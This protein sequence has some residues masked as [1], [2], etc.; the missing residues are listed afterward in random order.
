MNFNFRSMNIKHYSIL[1]F[2]LSSFLL[3]SC[4]KQKAK[5][6]VNDR[7]QD[8]EIRGATIC[9]SDAISAFDGFLSF[10]CVLRDN[11]PVQLISD[12]WKDFDVRF[13]LVPSG[14]YIIGSS[15]DDPFRDVTDLPMQKVNV[16]Y[17]YWIAENEVT[18]ELWNRVMPNHLRR[19]SDDPTM[20]VFP[21]TWLEAKQFANVASVMVGAAIGW[22]WDLPS[23]SEWE[24]AAN[25]GR[26][27]K[28]NFDTEE[29]S[30]MPQDGLLP[31]RGNTT[32]TWVNPVGRSKPN[33]FQ[34]FDMI[35]NVQEWTRNVHSFESLAER[36]PHH[37]LGRNLTP[38]EHRILRGG[39][40][41][42][43]ERNLRPE[44]RIAVPFHNMG[45]DAPI[46][47]RVVIRFTGDDGE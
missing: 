31:Y 41:R 24:I 43:S 42:S 28:P 44:A 19:E 36:F 37:R 18:F 9:S 1:V 7:A 45:D 33:D 17:S 22:K 25:G 11:E 12:Y 39:S 4:E 29:N 14:E 16:K 30:I 32:Q 21:V 27:V 2:S 23:E 8:S 46:G 26:A 13:R 20:P 35:G 3:G 5:D 34:L 6:L 10:R 15:I 38:Y 40:W 47:F